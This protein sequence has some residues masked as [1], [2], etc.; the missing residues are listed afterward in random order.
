MRAATISSIN[1]LF[2][3][4]RHSVV[5][6]NAT[7]EKQQHTLMFYRDSSFGYSLMETNECCQYDYK[8]KSHGI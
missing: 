1:R 7:K 2:T 6:P 5:K 8:T 4:R 3:Q